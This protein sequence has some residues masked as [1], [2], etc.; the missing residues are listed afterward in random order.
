[1]LKITTKLSGKVTNEQIKR[2]GMVLVCRGL[3][4]V[5][6]APATPAEKQEITFTDAVE[7]AAL[8]GTLARSLRR[9]LTAFNDKQKAMMSL[10]NNDDWVSANH[11]FI[12]QCE[13]CITAIDFDLNRSA[14]QLGKE[15]VKC[16]AIS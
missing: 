8:N 16:L 5:E 2:M 4:H 11:D 14:S 10:E 9:M 3:N 1:M 15:Q 6:L 12:T 7:H 13:A